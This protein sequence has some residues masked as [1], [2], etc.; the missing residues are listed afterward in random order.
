M[1]LIDRED[2]DKVKKY[3]LTESNG[4]VKMTVNNKR[5]LVHR[6][7][8]DL[9]AWDGVNYVDHIDGNPYNNKKIKFTYR[10]ARN[11]WTKQSQNS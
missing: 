9:I 1:F 10:D 7:L 6:F 5:Y 4:R 2:Y 8:L 11:K 3:A